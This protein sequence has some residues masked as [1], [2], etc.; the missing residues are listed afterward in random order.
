VSTAAGPRRSWRVPLIV[1]A[2]TGI[3]WIFGV[4]LVHALV[5][6][7]GLAVVVVVARTVDATPDPGW[8]PE[9]VPDRNGTRGELATL[10]WTMVGRDGRAGE[11]VFRRV[12]VVATG[13]LARLGLDLADPADADAIRALLGQRAWAVL[14]PAHGRPPRLADVEHTVARLERL[15]P[16][17]PPPAPAAHR[18][19]RRTT[20]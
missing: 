7:I 5:I 1:V 8:E 14:G 17:G 18:S 10:S 15:D 19:L 20:R 13:R 2:A 6:G 9:P 16:A 4:D 3:A 12:R 11:R